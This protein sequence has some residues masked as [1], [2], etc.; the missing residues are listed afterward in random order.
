MPTAWLNG[1]LVD[2][3]SPNIS[4][5]DTGLLHAAGVFT[6]MRASAGR[7]FRLEQHLQ[8]LRKSCDALFVPLQFSD[9]DLASAVDDVLRQN[10]LGDARLR[11][12]VTRGQSVQDPLHGTHLTPNCFLTATDLQPYPEQYYQQ[13]L[14]VMLNDEQKLNPY[15][16]QAGHKTLNYFSRLAALREAVR[17]GAGEALWFNVHNYLQSASVAN[18][19]VVKDGALVTPPTQEDLRDPKIAQACPY[20]KSNVLTG[21]TRAA[22]LELAQANAIPTRIEAL[23]VNHVLEADELF[24][25]NSIMQVM[26]VG[27]VE[28][29]KVG[30]GTPGAVTRR[31]SDLFQAA[32]RASDQG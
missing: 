14:T 19:F 3:D 30:D 21:I 9:A 27:R 31:V 12:T 10:N 16:M 23:T 17:R 26:P 7:V 25:T 13:G 32:V 5:R 6:T 15:D 8:R 24:L 1:N 11:L 4:L 28:Q 20:P 22:V 2:E 29:H 18:V